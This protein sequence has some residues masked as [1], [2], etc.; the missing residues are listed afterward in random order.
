WA[1][2]YAKELNDDG[3]FFPVWGTCLGWEW[4]AQVIFVGIVRETEC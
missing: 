3:D 2:K 4:M 1:L